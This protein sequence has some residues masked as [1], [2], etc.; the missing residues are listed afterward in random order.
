MRRFMTD[1]EY[2]HDIEED[3]VIRM[4][5][6]DRGYIHMMNVIYNELQEIKVLLKEK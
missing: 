4:N 5:F 2:L 3:I 1:G 6:R